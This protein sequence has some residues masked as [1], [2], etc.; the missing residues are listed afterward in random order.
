[1]KTSEIINRAQNIADVLG[2]E[3]SASNWS[4]GRCRRYDFEFVY[5]G[6]DGHRYIL[7]VKACGAREA[8]KRLLLVSDAIMAAARVGVAI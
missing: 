3:L 8:I 6:K 2:A 1:M 4:D 5:T 7:S